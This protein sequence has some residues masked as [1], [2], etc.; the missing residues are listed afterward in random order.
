[1]RD[2]SLLTVVE[3]RQLCKKMKLT[4]YTGLKKKQL[5][6]HIEYNTACIQKSKLKL[7]SFQKKA[8]AT[9]IHK[10]DSLMLVYN[11]GLGKTLTAV[12]VSQC[13]L[14]SVR[15]GKVIVVTPASL[16]SN[17][18][19]EM[20]RY[21]AKK[22]SQYSFLS[23]RNFVTN[24]PVRAECEKALLIL[25]EAHT[26]RTVTSS[27]SLTA[28]KVARKCNKVLLLTATPF[29]NNLHDFVPLINI[30]HQENIMKT[31]QLG[32]TPDKQNLKILRQYLDKKVH[33]VYKNTGCCFPKL[34]EKYVPLAMPV[35]YYDLYQKLLRG[36]KTDFKFSKP[37]AFYNGHRRAVNKVGEDYFSLKI[38]RMLNYVKKGQ[39]LVYTN[40]IEFGLNP[41][42]EFLDKKKISYR[43]I[44]GNLA[45]EKRGEIVEQFNKE[46]FRVLIITKA[47]GEG[48]DLKGVQNVIV[49]EPQ[50]NDAGLRQV[51][52]RAVRYK[53]HMHLP[54]SKQVVRVFKMI[55]TRPGYEKR[56][57]QDKDSGDAL[58]YQLIESKA[59][60][61]EQVLKVLKKCS[62]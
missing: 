30:L 8:V 4:N 9:V 49:M 1:M 23:Y 11:T 32:K 41:I 24:P 42:C 12:T 43:F 7:R 3:L 52:G 34:I 46:K 22:E 39:S 18:K 61:T 35:Q 40:W 37:E 36:K 13:Y 10:Q 57:R 5:I 15:H 45:R 20:K 19:K 59:G 29:V 21:G 17:F 14:D 51:V 38:K 53:S 58:L 16:I 56:W 62:I 2:L 33:F 55:L 6:R 54:A 44:S 26:L 50:W 31:G 48:L 27:T 60:A 47:G 28:V 25:D